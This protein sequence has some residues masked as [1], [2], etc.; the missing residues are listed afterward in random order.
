M[1]RPEHVEAW[2]RITSFVHQRSRAK[3]GLQL[4][5]AGRK[6]STAVPW[7]GGAPL[8]EGAWPLVAPSPIAYREGWPVPLELDRAG[9]D[10]VRDAFVRA[11]RLADDAGFDLLELHCA[12]GYLLGSFLS[13]LTNA[14][15]DEYG[16]G[17]EGRARFPLEVFTAMRAAWPARKPMSVRVS[18]T[19]WHEGG[20]TDEDVLAFTAA[21]KRAGCD[22]I[23]VSTGMTVADQK[24]LYGRMFQA[25]WSELIRNEVG[26]PTITVG[27]VTTADQVN[28]LV[29]SGRA[30]LCALARPH[31]ADPFWTLHAAA[32]QLWDAQPWPAQYELGRPPPT[33]R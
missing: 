27:A 23:D 10:A 26:V 8:T 29:A 15:S 20:I 6:G 14:R 3:I 18:A 7:E 24:P 13:P 31:L 2:R 32:Q 21:L 25:P 28:T 30:D 16:G 11:A 12:H 33:R 19:D 1:Y 17:I 9:M 22:L 5:H 4:G